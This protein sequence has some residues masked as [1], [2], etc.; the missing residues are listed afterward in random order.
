MNIKHDHLIDDPESGDVRFKAITKILLPPVEDVL[1]NN[2]NDNDRTKHCVS[3]GDEFVHFPQA[4]WLFES[5]TCFVLFFHSRTSVYLCWFARLKVELIQII[6]QRLRT[7]VKHLKRVERINRPCAQLR[8]YL[9]SPNAR[10][11]TYRLFES[12]MSSK[13]FKYCFYTNLIN[14]NEKILSEI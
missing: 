13:L 14:R 12:D 7:F 3:T 11:Y 4:S 10:L 9:L 6:Q 5:F 1:S 2:S 8:T